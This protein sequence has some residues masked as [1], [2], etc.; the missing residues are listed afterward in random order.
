MISETEFRGNVTNKANAIVGISSAIFGLNKFYWILM[1]AA[2]GILVLIVLLYCFTKHKC[3]SFGSGHSNPP[4]TTIIQ[5]NNIVSPQGEEKNVHRGRLF[6]SLRRKKKVLNEIKLEE[7]PTY[8]KLMK[9]NE[10]R[11][12]RKKTVAEQRAIEAALSK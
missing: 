3:G 11:K 4:S 5:N 1:G 8:F 7:N 6:N 2:G 10:E 9:E 12:V